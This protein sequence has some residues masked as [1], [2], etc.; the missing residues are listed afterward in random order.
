MTYTVP[1]VYTRH[2]QNGGKSKSESVA[3]A[4]ARSILEYTSLCTFAKCSVID[5]EGNL[6]MGKYFVLS[7]VLI[8]GRSKTLLHVLQASERQ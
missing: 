3:L 5:V 6:L 2:L 4:V 8:E 7:V 1:R